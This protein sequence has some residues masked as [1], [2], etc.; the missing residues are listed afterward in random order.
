[1]GRTGMQNTG[2][3][4]GNVIGILVCFSFIVILAMPD[5][6]GMPVDDEE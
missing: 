5:D 6:F 3:C 1:M 2:L 4:M